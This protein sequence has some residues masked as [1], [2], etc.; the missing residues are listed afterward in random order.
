[1]PSGHMQRAKTQNDVRIVQSDQDLC[2]PL[3]GILDTIEYT[4]V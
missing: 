3:K 4:D 2:R 1:M